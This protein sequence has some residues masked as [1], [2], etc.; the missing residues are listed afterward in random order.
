[1]HAVVS[2]TALDRSS[3]AC[4][5]ILQHPYYTTLRMRASVK[6]VGCCAQRNIGCLLGEQPQGR[7]ARLHGPKTCMTPPSVIAVGSEVEVYTGLYLSR[8]STWHESSSEQHGYSGLCHR[9]SSAPWE[10]LFRREQY[11][12]Q[13]RSRALC[14]SAQLRSTR[15][16]RRALASTLLCVGGGTRVKA[17]SLPLS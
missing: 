14:E 8:F 2:G 11:S 15:G 12:R 7:L 10:T 4:V 6:T 1:M 16:C 13:L 5:R 9:R 17:T 3:D